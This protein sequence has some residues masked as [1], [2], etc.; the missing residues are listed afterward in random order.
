MMATLPGSQ[1]PTVPAIGIPWNGTYLAGAPSCGSSSSSSSPFLFFSVRAIVS[2]AYMHLPVHWVV[3]GCPVF[4]PL[5]NPPISNTGCH[6]CPRGYM[7]WIFLGSTRNKQQATSFAHTTCTSTSHTTE[8][9]KLL[10]YPTTGVFWLAFVLYS[11]GVCFCVCFMTWCRMP[12]EGGRRTYQRS[13]CPHCSSR[14]KG[15]RAG[16]GDFVKGN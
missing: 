9:P 10:N 5:L 12:M 8:F 15:E 3:R 13:V 16:E 2:F 14:D 1:P 4:W 11:V 6:G 7:L